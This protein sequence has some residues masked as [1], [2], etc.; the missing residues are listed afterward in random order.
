[1]NQTKSQYHTGTVSRSLPFSFLLCALA[2][3]L[4][5]CRGSAPIIGGNFGAPNPQSAADPEPAFKEISLKALS[6]KVLVIMYHDVVGERGPGTEWFDI[7]QAQF[8]EQIELVKMNGGNFISVEQL[9]DHLTKGT[10]IPPRS[11]VL[12]FDDNYTGIWDWAVPVL[13]RFDVPYAVYVHTNFVGGTTGRP[14]MTWAQLRELKRT[15]K[16][17]IGAHTH[18]HPEDLTLLSRE[19]QRKELEESKKILEAQLDMTITSMAWANG[20]HDEFTMELAREL[21]Y[22]IAFDMNSGIA[23]QSKSIMAVHRFP[24]NKMEQGWDEREIQL[25]TGFRLGVV[26]L[27]PDTPVDQIRLTKGTIN[28]SFLVGGLPKTML[29]SSR[30]GVSEFVQ[31]AG[32]V[33]GINGGF[34]LLA[35]IRETDNRMIGPIKTDAN[36]VVLPSAMK[37]ELDRLRNRPLVVWSPEKIAFIPYVPERM[38]DPE[39]LKTVVPSFTNCF[40]GGAWLVVDGRPL[41][42]E[43]ILS[44]GSQ[45]AQ[46]PRRRAFFGVMRDGRIVAG[47]SLSSV[48][49]S[50]LAQAAAEIGCL[51]AVLLDS[52]FSTSLVLGDQILAS[53]HSTKDRPSRPVPHAIVLMGT[54]AEGAMNPV[55]VIS[56]LH[57]RQ[58]DFIFGRFR[59]PL[60]GS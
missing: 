35:A 18:T 13:K 31:E 12:T 23:Q 36:P 55:P 6:D 19:Q 42:K 2:L 47:A 45:D 32:A 40:L 4:V 15:T 25:G 30:M 60:R 24:W 54:L 44:H 29:S 5:G 22:K 52:G 56:T 58:P 50:M 16:I 1:M 8:E 33:G 7:T 34:F 59:D 20:K 27:A 9:T 21:G 48:S 28:Y 11:V 10:P 3:L 17:H 14:K 43:Q 53:G 51:Y 39:L 57:T 49:S 26:D 37:T 38:D 46:D 41:T